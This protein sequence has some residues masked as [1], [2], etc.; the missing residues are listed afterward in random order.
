MSRTYTVHR[1]DNN[2]ADLVA[3]AKRLGAWVRVYPPLD[4]LVWVGKWQM[5][6]PVEIKDPKK[7]GHKDEY[8]P[9]QLKFFEDCKKHNAK[10]WVW[11]NDNDVKR[12][13]GGVPQPCSK[14]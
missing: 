8:T 10:W 1:K 2:H 5:W 6:M 3:T 9:A 14:G 12:D 7:E 4:L 11:R 13:L